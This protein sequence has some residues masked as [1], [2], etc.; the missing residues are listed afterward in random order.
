MSIRHILISYYYICNQKKKKNHYFVET[1]SNNI[2]VILLHKIVTLIHLYI[3]YLEEIVGE[4]PCKHGGEK[5][6][7]VS[8][9]NS[10]F[11]L[12]FNLLFHFTS[13]LTT[14]CNYIQI[15]KKWNSRDN[16]M[17]QIHNTNPHNTAAIFVVVS[18]TPSLIF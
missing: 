11:C 7:C 10:F 5:V 13:T 15:E 16:K 4:G 6:V 2:L 9:Q 12:K 14:H 17:A 1:F 3:K 8:P 18:L